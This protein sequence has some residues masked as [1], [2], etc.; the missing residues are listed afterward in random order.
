MSNAAP[1]LTLE[2]LR[3]FSP[4]DF[5]TPQY[6]Q[7]LLDSLQYVQRKAG[8]PLFQRG[9]RS[10]ALYYLL[11]GSVWLGEEAVRRTLQAGSLEACHALNEMQPQQEA[12]G[13]LTD[14]TLFA[15]ERG[16]L[17]RLLGWSQ[18]A[19]YKVVSLHGG[20][21]EEDQQDD[22][23]AKLLRTPLFG[24]LPPSH[25]HALLARFEFIEVAA[26]ETVVRYGEPGEHFYVLKQGRAAVTLP[27][28]YQRETSQELQSGDFFG[29]EALVSGAVRAATVTM[30]EAGVLARLERSLFLEL[31]RPTLIPRISSQQLNQLMSNGRRQFLLLDVRLPPEY[32]IAHQPGSVSLP[33]A[34]LRT[35]AASLDRDT[36]YAVTPEGGIRSELAVHLLNQLG[37]EAYLLAESPGQP[38][39]AA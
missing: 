39:V 32:R 20:A 17:E 33:V 34:N 9:D 13:A 31:I 7:Q 29:E 37:F 4:F 35:Q 25:L 16:L 19:E 21:D 11:A 1:S 30:L 28:A 8:S 18:S 15:L 36:L 10:L 24:R 12:V 38:P 27:S 23:L 6:Q 3:R 14:V 22:W 26:G 2:L 5:L